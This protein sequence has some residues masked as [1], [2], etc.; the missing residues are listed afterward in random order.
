[1]VVLVK[2]TQVEAVDTVT[3]G[4]L[5]DVQLWVVVMYDVMGGKK[6]GEVVVVVDTEHG[7]GVGQ[8]FGV[9]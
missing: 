8:E 4:Q 5:V 9:D 6:I 2:G 7:D 1:V 3:V